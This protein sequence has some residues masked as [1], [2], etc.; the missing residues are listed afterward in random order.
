MGI[1]KYEGRIGSLNEYV[2]WQVG[3]RKIVF[4]VQK[5]TDEWWFIYKV[6]PGP[7]CK[8][9]TLC[10]FVPESREEA[11]NYARQKAEEFD[12]G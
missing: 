1:R 7:K 5:G 4:V 6:H 3:N 9:S 8:V 11:V 10:A 12:N 2:E